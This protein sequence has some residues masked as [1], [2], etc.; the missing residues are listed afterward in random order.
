MIMRFPDQ[1]LECYI[2]HPSSKPF[3]NL[4]A[5]SSINHSAHDTTRKQGHTSE[6]SHWK[7]LSLMP[8][9]LEL[10]AVILTI[11]RMK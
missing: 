5:P 3:D 11:H 6:H 9:A 2:L 4:Q 7:I 8:P 1:H 10:A